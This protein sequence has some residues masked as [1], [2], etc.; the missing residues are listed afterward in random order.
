MTGFFDDSSNAGID[1]N[2]GLL[3]VKFCAVALFVD[4]CMLRK[5]LFIGFPRNAHDIMLG[6]GFI[7]IEVIDIIYA[8]INLINLADDIIVGSIVQVHVCTGYHLFHTGED[9]LCLL[10]L[11]ED[12]LILFV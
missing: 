5:T 3:I 8:V 6:I 2:A 4:N 7:L 10:P 12:S 11:Y 1:S 9:C